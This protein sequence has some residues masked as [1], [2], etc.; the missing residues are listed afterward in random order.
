M[1]V[2]IVGNAPELRGSG[3]GKL[4]D[5][6]DVIIRCNAWDCSE[7]YWDDVGRKCDIWVNGVQDIKHERHPS[8]AWF[9]WPVFTWRHNLKVMA[10]PIAEYDGHPE[11]MGLSDVCRVHEEY[12]WDGKFPHPSTGLLAMQMA[13]NKYPGVTIWYTGIS[14]VKDTRR[15]WTDAD[16]GSG[17]AHCPEKELAWIE[18]KEMLLSLDKYPCV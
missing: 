12:G 7:E 16:P 2:I 18:S 3:L 9:V 10:G 6:F 13:M 15:Y 1:K 8:E 17:G 14:G 4:I 5:S 11:I